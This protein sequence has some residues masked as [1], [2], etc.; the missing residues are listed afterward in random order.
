MGF[1]SCIVGI[2]CNALLCAGKLLIGTLSGSVSITADAMNNLSDAASSIVTLVGF[3]LAEQPADK[4]HPY[5]HARYEYISGL[6]VAS[7]ILVIGFE[8][9]FSSVRKILHPVSVDLTVLTFV[10][11]LVSIL[12]KLWMMVFFRTLG[13]RI[14][15]TT[16]K[17]TSVDS[18]NDVI[19]S[20][21]VLFGC[22]VE[23]Y[24]SLPVDGWFGVAVA[25]FILYSGT[26]IIKETVSPLLGKQADKSLLSDLSALVCD[27]P[28]ILG[29]HDLLVHDYGPGQCFATVHAEMDAEKDPLYC[30]DVIDEIEGLALEKLN[31]H[32]VIH[33]DP[34]VVNDEEWNEMRGIVEEIVTEIDPSLSIHDFRIVRGVS[35]PKLV[36]DVAVPY[37]MCE[38]NKD[39]KDR[40]NKALLIRKKDYITVIRFDH[41]D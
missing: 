39:L 8:L 6:V 13:K 24:T 41:I 38:C 33:Y 19:A 3:K 15:S 32:L 27:H 14:D 31:V 20:L 25:L 1:Q 22:A 12:V 36:F 21:A 30:H 2:V 26:G 10:I 40:I 18:R 5:G 11:L 23:Y 35:L 4:E 7:L 9:A 28:D 16:L 34:V 17:A 29:I 37:D